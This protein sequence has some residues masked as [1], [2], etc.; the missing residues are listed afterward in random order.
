MFANWIFFVIAFFS[1]FFWNSSAFIPNDISLNPFYDKNMIPDIP[2]M[3][4]LKE[5][6]HNFVPKAED[7][8]L[9]PKI[10]EFPSIPKLDFSELTGTN[11]GPKI[12]L[13]ADEIELPIKPEPLAQPTMP[14]PG[15]LDLTSALDMF[16]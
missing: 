4:L 5:K 14:V 13:K 10:I 15:F 7:G 1:V 6:S 8:T 2:E 3:A 9:F 12:G 11:S 16:K